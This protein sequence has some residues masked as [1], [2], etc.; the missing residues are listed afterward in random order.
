MSRTR[1]CEPG[2]EIYFAGLL[3]SIPPENQWDFTVECAALAKRW[4]SV[5][6]GSSE[7]E[8]VKDETPRA[9]RD[10]RGVLMFP[11]HEART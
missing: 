7:S 1:G 2:C 3:L 10:G 11:N 8:P 5:D 9:K 6:T 4:R